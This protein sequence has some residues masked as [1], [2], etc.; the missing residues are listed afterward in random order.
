M[1][2]WRELQGS[3]NLVLGVLAL[4]RD[5][6]EPH[7][8]ALRLA[9]LSTS[10]DDGRVANDVRL[11]PV[12]G[13]ARQPLLGAPV[14]ARLCTDVQEGTKGGDIRQDTHLLHVLEPLLGAIHVPRAAACLNEST[15]AHNVRLD[16][17]RKHALEHALGLL[18]LAGAC[19]AVQQRG[20]AHDAAGDAILQHGREP[21]LRAVHVAG[22]HGGVD[23]RVVCDGVRLH[24][25]ARD[26]LPEEGLRPDQ[27]ARL[28]AHI[29]G[30]T[31]R[32]DVWLDTL[33]RH[34]RH[35]LLSTLRTAPL[36]PSAED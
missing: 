10:V 8:G 30:R 34:Q 17:V 23:E 5:V 11:H 28:R 14:V 19:M 21:L 24:L 26:D 33:L 20:E 18:D 25:A 7:L 1:A 32:H 35:Q 13:H 31:E 29:H 15:V 16:A 4:A 22:L 9:S 3:P 6:P 27:V 36:G 2:G 12:L